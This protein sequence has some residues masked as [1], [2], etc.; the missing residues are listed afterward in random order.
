VGSGAQTGINNSTTK[1]FSK[2]SCKDKI[3]LIGCGSNFSIFCTENNE[4]FGVGSNTDGRLG[5]QWNNGTAIPQKIE[6]ASGKTVKQISCGYSH[7]LLLTSE[8]AV[9]T[10]GSNEHGQLGLCDENGNK[11][12]NV[13]TF[14][15]ISDLMK[16]KVVSA[17]AGANFSIVNVYDKVK[18]FFNK[19][20]QKI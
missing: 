16:K 18:F 6:L 2:V 13:N 7:A 19:N 15:I 9:Y 5:L 14:R 8:G 20:K 1:I 4:L 17:Y 10:T 12:G 3:K 11:L